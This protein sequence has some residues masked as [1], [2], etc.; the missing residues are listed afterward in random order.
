MSK[1]TDQNGDKDKQDLEPQQLPSD[2]A[3]VPSTTEETDRN[4]G[5]RMRELVRQR[6]QIEQKQQ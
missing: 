3:S 4:Y 1:L 6:Q 5:E 2:P